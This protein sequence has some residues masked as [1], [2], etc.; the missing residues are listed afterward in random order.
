ME[1]ILIALDGG[2]TKIRS[3]IVEIVEQNKI[4]DCEH[5]VETIYQN[6]PGFQQDFKPV[7][8]NEQL[9]QFKT[10]QIQLTQVEIQQGNIIVQAAV[11][12]IRMLIKDSIKPI[13]LGIGMPGLKT[14]NGQGIAVMANGP[15]IPNYTEQL[16][17]ELQKWNIRLYKNIHGLGSD[18]DY[19]G[20]GE[21]YAEAGLMREV[22]TAYYLGI[23]TG[24]ADAMKI[25]GE[26]IRFD[27]AKSWIAKTWELL[28][29]SMDISMEKCTSMRGIWEAYEARSHAMH[30]SEGNAEEVFIRANG[31]EPDAVATLQTMCQALSSLILD[32]MHTLYFGGTTLKLNNPDRSLEPKHPFVGNIWDRIILGQRMGYLWKTYPFFHEYFYNALQQKIKA[33]SLDFQRAYT[34]IQDKIQAS[35]LREAPILGAAIAAY[36]KIIH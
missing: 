12:S 16:N 14:A 1:Y 29:P 4:G 10:Q 30:N 33:Y 23:G 17:Q 35:S 36:K 27:Q 20:I 13:V 9:Y 5:V 3:G 2:A 21:N 31:K 24:V 11:Q 34:N 15:R 19:C 28:D 25:H 7:N 26:I 22:S 6:M 32:R 18:A 8:I